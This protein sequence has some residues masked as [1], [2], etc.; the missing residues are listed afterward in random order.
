MQI[1]I[2]ASERFRAVSLGMRSAAEIQPRAK[3]GGALKLAPSGKPTYPSGVVVMRD[4]GSGQDRSV[5]IAVCEYAEF[6]PLTNLVTDGDTWITPYESN[7]RVAISVIAERLIPA[8][9]V[10]QECARRSES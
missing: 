7:G 3:E 2:D 1:K 6:P 5:T 8:E 9:G 4:D 10:A